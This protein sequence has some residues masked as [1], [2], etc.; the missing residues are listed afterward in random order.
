MLRKLICLSFLFSLLSPLIAQSNNQI[1][2]KEGLA[3]KSFN[4]FAKNMFT[5]DPVE[6]LIVKDDWAVPDEGDSLTFGNSVSKWKKIFSDG[7]GWF[8]R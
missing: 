4:F 1:I 5:P 6:D 3:I 2:F 8:E 7:T